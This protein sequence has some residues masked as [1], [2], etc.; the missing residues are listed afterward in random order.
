MWG[1]KLSILASKLMNKMRRNKLSLLLYKF[2]NKMGSTHIYYLFCS[3]T[4]CPSLPGTSFV[5]KIIPTVTFLK[6]GALVL[7]S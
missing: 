3:W 4:A 1:D 6:L 2:M 5:M 7:M